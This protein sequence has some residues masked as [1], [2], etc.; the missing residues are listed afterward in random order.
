MEKNQNLTR[1]L[2]Q[3]REEFQKFRGIISPIRASVLDLNKSFFHLSLEKMIEWCC[4]IDVKSGINP[5]IVG[6]FAAAKVQDTVHFSS[7]FCDPR[8]WKDFDIRLAKIIAMKKAL[9]YKNKSKFY[10]AAFIHKSTLNTIIKNN[11]KKV[12]ETNSPVSC[13]ICYYTNDDYDIAKQ[14]DYF[15]DRVGRYFKF[16]YHP[17]IYPSIPIKTVDYSEQ[18]E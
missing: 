1:V 6:Y 5:N 4:N 8:D 18:Q 15:Y 10:N 11:K 2:N 7:S 14:W 3:T 16:Y 17:Q 9:S 12:I 13:S